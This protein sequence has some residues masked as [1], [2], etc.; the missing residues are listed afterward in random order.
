MTVKAVDACLLRNVEKHLRF[1]HGTC[2]FNTVKIYKKLDNSPQGPGKLALEQTRPPCQGILFQTDVCLPSPVCR[3]RPGLETIVYSNG[4]YEVAP[5][6]GIL[7]SRK[8]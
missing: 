6:Q 7:A 4:M 8:G 2:I 5:A 3:D 1:P